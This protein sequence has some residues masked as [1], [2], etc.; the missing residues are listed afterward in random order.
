MPEVGGGGAG[1]YPAGEGYGG[2]DPDTGEST[3]RTKTLAAA[4]KFDPLT[5]RY[6][7]ASTGGL[8]D[9]H[10][11][12]ARARHLLGL[13]RR[14]IAS[15]PT[16]GIPIAR[17]RIARPDQRQRE[18]EDAVNIALAPL[19]AAGDVRIK[20]VTLSDPYNGTFYT[21]LVNLR[22]ADAT[23]ARITSTLKD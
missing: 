8:A 9:E 19:L 23:P 12:I 18:A 2:W 11:V 5:R 14:G 10:P 16:V 15:A 6:E 1:A 7:L 4:P 13:R 17:M 22:A 21:E 3:V 20:S